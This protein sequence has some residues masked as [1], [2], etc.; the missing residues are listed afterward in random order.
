MTVTLMRPLLHEAAGVFPG[1]PA[2]GK[3]IYLDGRNSYADGHGLTI[4]TAGA[5]A[6]VEFQ[7]VADHRDSRKHV[8]AIADQGCAFDG[9]RDV[10]VLDQISLGGGEHELAIGNIDLS[11]AKVHRV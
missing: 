9:G 10:A 1:G 11:A 3:A 4:F 8:G 6:F 7:V 5:D 2:N